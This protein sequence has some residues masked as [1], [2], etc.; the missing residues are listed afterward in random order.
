MVCSMPTP[1][2]CTWQWQ[3]HTIR[4]QVVRPAA[5]AIAGPPI[6]C[7][8]GFG[9]SSDHWRHN[10]PV[11]G[12]HH[13]TFAIDLI[14]FGGSDKPAP[15]VAL[16]YTFET[17]AAQVRDFCQQV[18]GGPAMV[19]G[20][21]IGC[22]VALQ[23]AVDDPAGTLG[24]VLLNCSLRLLHERRRDQIAWHERLSTPV[25]QNLL[26]IRPVGHLFFSV[27]ARPGMIRQLLG[28]AYC[29]SEAITDDLVAAILKPAQSPG[30][31]DVFLAFVRYSQGPLPEDLLPHLACPALVIWGQDDPWEPVAL[32]RRFGE[33]GAVEAVVE[34]PGVGHCPQDEAPEQVN[35][36]ILDWVGRH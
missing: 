4:Y 34:L 31:A 20:N 22:V 2:D 36:L 3:G 10:L 8:H 13:P 17:W 5:A 19:V 33:Y 12:Q 28:Q 14:G 9:A 29:R 15:Q 32:G 6:L 23:A 11:L 1:T 26:G 35:P 27:L 30:A 24:L 21:S 16:N 18:I 25:M 7:I